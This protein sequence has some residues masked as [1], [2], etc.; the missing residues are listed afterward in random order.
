MWQL[1]AMSRSDKP[2]CHFSRRTSRMVRIDSLLLGI[3][4]SLRRGVRPPSPE[5]IAHS[6]TGLSHA[7]IGSAHLVGNRCTFPWRITAHFRGESL[8][9]FEE[10]L[11]AWL[12]VVP[13]STTHAVTNPACS[14]QIHRPWT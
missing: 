3:V 12:T 8:R 4:P 9:F 13:G 11:Q 14:R 6:Q 5:G 7:G 1:A 2:H 10:I